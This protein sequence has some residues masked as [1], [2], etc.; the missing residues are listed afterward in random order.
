MTD[1]FK[2]DGDFLDWLFFGIDL[3]FVLYLWGHQ[4]IALSMPSPQRG[5]PCVLSPLPED[6]LRTQVVTFQENWR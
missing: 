6:L 2:A 4:S 3:R 5:G 1:F